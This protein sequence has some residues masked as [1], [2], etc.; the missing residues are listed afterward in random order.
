MSRDCY[1]VPRKPVR[2]RIAVGAC[3]FIGTLAPVSGEEEAQELIQAVRK[4][5][6]DATHHAYALS[7]GCGASLI[8]RC[9]DDGEPALTAGAPML[10]VF[11]GAGLSDLVMVGTRYFGGVKLGIGGLTRAYSACARACLEQAELAEKE[12]RFKFNL[13]VG[14]EHLGAVLRYLEGC[15]GGIIGIEYGEQAAVTAT[16]PHDRAEKARADFLELTRGQGCWKVLEDE[17]WVLREE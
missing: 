12:K 6:P 16:L 9:H 13:A 10:Q 8:E 11:K 3:R 1:Y 2:A 4:E 14:Y 5:F 7:I 17:V 15:G